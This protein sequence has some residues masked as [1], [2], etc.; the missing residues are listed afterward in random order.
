MLKNK[1]FHTFIILSVLAG[2]ASN[3]HKEEGAITEEINESL[4]TTATSRILQ[5]QVET[6]NFG[7]DSSKVTIEQEEKIS[8]A[9]DAL[10]E[11]PEESIVLVKGYTDKYGTEA[12]NKELGMERAQEV[13]EEL[14]RRGLTSDQ[15]II[16]SFGEADPIVSSDNKDE[17]RENRRATIEIVTKSKR[18]PVILSE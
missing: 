6:V 11:A 2:C 1:S 13:K 10:N 12:Y 17:L 3:A 16:E 4:D 14:L 15:I 5:D 7:F 8:K 9:L 18:M